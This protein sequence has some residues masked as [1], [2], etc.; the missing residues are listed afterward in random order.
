MLDVLTVNFTE[1]FKQGKTVLSSRGLLDLGEF[2]DMPCV[3]T[4]FTFM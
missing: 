1:D 2:S 4:S 3:P